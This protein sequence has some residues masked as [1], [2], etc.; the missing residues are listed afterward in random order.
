LWKNEKFTMG[1]IDFRAFLMQNII[2]FVGF[3][4]L[5]WIKGNSSEQLG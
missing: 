1:K 4:G 2:S 5:S 3:S